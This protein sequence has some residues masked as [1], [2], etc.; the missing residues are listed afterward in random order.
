MTN[1]FPTYIGV[2]RTQG[3]ILIGWGIVLWF[4]AAMNTRLAGAFGA[5]E[6]IGPAVLFALII[7]GTV[8]FVYLTRL[9]ARLRPSQTAVAIAIVTA[10][11]LL[12][13]G[14]AFA[15]FRWLYWQEIASAAA[16]IF[17]GAGVA[18]ALGIAMNG[19]D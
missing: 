9:I 10:T 5:F 8:P 1:E 16:S 19:R 13:D 17:W 11:A 6:G 3:L 2:N 12:C 15:G 4:V 14:V 7:P 18:I